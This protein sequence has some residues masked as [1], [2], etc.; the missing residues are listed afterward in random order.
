MNKALPCFVCNKNKWENLYHSL[1]KCRQ[2]GFIRARNKYFRIK[3]E[4]L[5]T[6]E[7]FNGLDYLN[8]QAEKKALIKN[9]IRRLKIIRNYI[10]SGNL[11]EIGCAYGY[12][13]GLAEK[14][15]NTTGIDLDKNVTSQ[16]KKNTSH[17][18]I[19]TGDFLKKKNGE[20]YDVV[21]MFD[22]IE[23]LYNP[24]KYLRKI[25]KVL[26]PG[27]L[28]FIETGDIG[29]LLPKIRR[30]K[31]RL[32][33]PPIHLSYFS[34]KT[35]TKLLENEG[36]RVEETKYPDFFRTLRQTIFKTKLPKLL[37]NSILDLSFKLN[38]RDI[39]FVI[40]RKS[41]N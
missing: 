30:S 5:Y 40:A 38:T 14:K 9:F 41:T 19:I 37:P 15:F 28:L 3:P 12:F 10:K 7:Y 16:A 36:F 39:M 26:K 8:Y 22:V 2:C 21:C 11:L 34:R 23:H 24:Q 17:T 33:Y 13:L 32:I 31:W 35:L 20:K 4:Q 18:K 6:E 1:V 27:G 29:T 25:K